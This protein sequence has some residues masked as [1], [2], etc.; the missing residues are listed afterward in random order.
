MQFGYKDILYHS[1]IRWLSGRKILKR[2]FYLRD[3]IEI[4]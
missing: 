1:N 3:E 4:F 2:F